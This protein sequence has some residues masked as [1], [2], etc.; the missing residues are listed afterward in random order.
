MTKRFD[1]VEEMRPLP[2]APFANLSEQIG[3]EAPLAYD[4][5]RSGDD[6]CMDFD[7]PGVDPS[8]IHLSLENQYLTISV[9]REL[10]DSD[11]KLIERGRVHGLFERRLVFPSHWKLDELRASV[12]NGVLH[13]QAPLRASHAARAIEVEAL[14]TPVHPMV[15]A[16]PS[17]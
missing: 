5:Y 8:A 17:P 3:T 7:V 6:L 2:V 12:A 13:L 11:I 10:P 14:D 16:R 9:S 15:A 4:V 1:P